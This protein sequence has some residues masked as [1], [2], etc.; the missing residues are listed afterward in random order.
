SGDTGSQPASWRIIF[1]NN[2]NLRA[3][4]CMGPFEV[5]RA[6]AI[7]VRAGERT[8]GN[9]FVHSFLDDLGIPFNGLAKR[10]LGSPVGPFDARRPHGLQMLHKAWQILK[11]APET[12][13]F[14]RRS[15]NR[16]PYFHFDAGTG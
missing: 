13:E 12:E 7:Y 5:N 1:H 3:M 15:V 6:R 8:P 2:L 10:G 11:V 4:S 14:F 16:E 9:E